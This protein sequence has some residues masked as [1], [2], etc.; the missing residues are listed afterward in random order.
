MILFLAVICILTTA[1]LLLSRSI[2][3]CRFFTSPLALSPLR[4]IS[5]S[6]VP[7]ANI[8]MAI[9]YAHNAHVATWAEVIVLFA[10]VPFELSSQD[11]H[12]YIVYSKSAASRFMQVESN[13]PP[14]HLVSGDNTPPAPT[15]PCHRVRNPAPLSLSTTTTIQRS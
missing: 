11:E 13:Q 5:W 10:A 12:R 15:R 7:P 8:C 2:Y 9:T 14:H 1:I 6:V 4:K 3:R